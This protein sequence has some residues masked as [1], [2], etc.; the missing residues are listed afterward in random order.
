LL[1]RPR[2]LETGSFRAVAPCTHQATCGLLA[3]ENARHWCHHFAQ[4]PGE[5]F[6]DSDWAHFSSELGIDLRRTPYSFLALERAGVA[7]E[8]ASTNLSRVIGLPRHCKGYSKVLSCQVGG[9]TELILQKRDARD[10]FDS[11]R[12]PQAMP[13]YRW[14]IAKGKIVGGAQLD[15]GTPPQHG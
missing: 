13:V 9:V 3:S 5:V 11:V 14:E 10:L 8:N 4:P 6:H 12:D 1:G 7:D 2:L 15:A